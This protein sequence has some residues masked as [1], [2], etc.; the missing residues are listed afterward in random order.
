MERE[1]SKAIGC[2]GIAAYFLFGV[3]ILGFLMNA[4]QGEHKNTDG[5]WVSFDNMLN[6]ALFTLGL[7]LVLYTID[8][9]RNKKYD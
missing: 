2:F 5:E 9:I 1:K 4:I 8:R 6:T 7:G 3:G